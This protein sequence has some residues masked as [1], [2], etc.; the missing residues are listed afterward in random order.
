MMSRPGAGVPGR[1]A[2]LLWNID[3]GRQGNRC[4]DAP[5]RR[6]REFRLRIDLNGWRQL[7]D[8]HWRVRGI[9]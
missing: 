2:S 7:S 1:G 6:G 8:R 9:I 3:T 5:S 4:H